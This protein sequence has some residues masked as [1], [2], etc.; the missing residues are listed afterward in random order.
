MRKSAV[1]SIRRCGPFAAPR[2][3][4]NREQPT[5]NPS[6]PATF[7]GIRGEVQVLNLRLFIGE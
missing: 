3:G 5:Q 2:A 4:N 6:V 1:L 7:A